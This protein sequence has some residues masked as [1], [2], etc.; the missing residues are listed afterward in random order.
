M[1]TLQG[2]QWQTMNEY[3]LHN[4][5]LIRPG[6]DMALG[7]IFVQDHAIAA[8]GHGEPPEAFGAK[9]IDCE[10]LRL[11]PGLIDV[12]THGIHAFNYDRGPGHLEDAAEQLG[13]YGV[14]TVV[15]TIVPVMSPD[16]LKALDDFCAIIPDI[17]EVSI[18]GV[19]LEG[20]FVAITG[21]ACETRD[22]DVGLLD[23]L[24]DACENNV[25][26]MSIA[27]E[28]PNIIP[29]IERL[30]E[31]GV[32]PFI[33]HTRA[34]VEQTVAAIDAGARHATHFYD[35]FPV[36]EESDP[37]V[38]PVGVV[39]T[40]LGDTR[41]TCD[42]IADGVHVHPMAIKAA[43]AAKGFEGVTLITDSSFGSGLGTGRYETPWGYHVEVK[44]GDA[45]RVADPDHPLVGGLAGSALTMDRGINNL[46]RWLEL[47]EEQV[48]AMG[49][50]NPASVVELNYKGKFE[51]GFDAD[52]VLWNKVDGQLKPLRTWVGGNIVYEA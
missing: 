41:A 13:Q 6:I 12:H 15:P 27:P 50:S 21:A 39:E 11:T 46:M 22:G 20:P 7:Y 47:P 16:F 35:V 49:T 25:A 31:R 30:R 4:A 14:T 10:G 42:F 2:L 29:V 52:L 9:L 18:P 36:P 17:E 28:V 3:V 19:H 24:I 1:A 26:V 51:A 32:V 45:P 23:D 48:W 40:I 37:G 8:V 33:T 5:Q 43:V 34:S 38:R 44:E